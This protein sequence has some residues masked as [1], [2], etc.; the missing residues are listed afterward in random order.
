M[1]F[2]KILL[3]IIFLS[4]AGN[5]GLHNLVQLSVG[6]CGEGTI[7]PDLVKQA[8][9]GSLDVLNEGSLEGGDLA[10]VNLVQEAT[11]TAVNDGDLVL[12]GHGHVLALLQQLSQP[13]TSVQQLLGGGVKIGTEL[14]E[15]RPHGTGR[16]RAS[17]NRRPA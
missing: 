1:A 12:N 9:V 15:G 13:D 7:L 8:L 6:V 11:D 4:P 5:E 16:A 17:W 2:R 3:K 10:G 14:G